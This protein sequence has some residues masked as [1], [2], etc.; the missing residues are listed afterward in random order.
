MLC[1]PRLYA[2][3]SLKRDGWAD[4]FVSGGTF[5]AAICRGLIEAGISPPSRVAA[6]AFS[7]A[8]CRGLIEAQDHH[9]HDYR[10]YDVFRGYMP[11]PH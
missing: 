8:I 11:R 6:L 10:A 9:C 3:A 2:A 7:A 5:S 4:W 1:F